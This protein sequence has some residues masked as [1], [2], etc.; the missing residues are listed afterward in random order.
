M[1]TEASATSEESPI[2][3]LKCGEVVSRYQFNRVLALKKEKNG[4]ILLNDLILRCRE[5]PASFDLWFVYYEGSLQRLRE[6]G[7][8]DSDGEVPPSIRAIA[9]SLSD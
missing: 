1:Q 3:T 8:L 7:L 5:D 6:L 2:V 4:A 9:L